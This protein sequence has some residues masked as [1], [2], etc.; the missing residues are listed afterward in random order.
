MKSKLLVLALPLML[1]ASPAGA[2]VLWTTTFSGVD[3]T[4]RSMTNTPE[5]AFTDTL[6]SSYTLTFNGTTPAIR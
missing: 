4:A 1:A 2:A 3:N 6:T 5:G